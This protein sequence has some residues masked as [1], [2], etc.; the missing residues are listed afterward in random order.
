[1]KS[2]IAV[3]SLVALVACTK[4]VIVPTGS[5]A[6]PEAQQ[7]QA[8]AAR[9]HLTPEQRAD[10]AIL[11]DCYELRDGWWQY[12]LCCTHRDTS[13]IIPDAEAPGWSWFRSAPEMMD[14]VEAAKVQVGERCGENPFN[15]LALLAV[16]LQRVNICARGPWADALAVRASGDVIEEY[17]SVAF[18]DGCWYGPAYKGSWYFGG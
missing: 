1:M 6:P 8:I 9:E 2:L 5:E 10:C 3:L 15:T 7:C 17:H 11:C 12:Q 4:E 13:C 14:Q 16:E 18:T